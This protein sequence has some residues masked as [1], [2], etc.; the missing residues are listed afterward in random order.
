[1]KAYHRPTFPSVEFLQSRC[2]PSSLA[3]VHPGVTVACRSALWDD[4]AQRGRGGRRRGKPALIDRASSR[5][6]APMADDATCTRS[7]FL[8]RRASRSRCLAHDPGH[9][10]SK[11]TTCALR[12]CSACEEGGGEE[13]E[14]QGK[15]QKRCAC[16]YFSQHQ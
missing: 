8:R 6:R 16:L 4:T 7:L 12:S 15:S 14:E 1:M 2:A 3:S 13:K 10:R 5:V 9:R 11:G